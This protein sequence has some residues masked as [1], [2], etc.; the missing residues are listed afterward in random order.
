[1]QTG[2]LCTFKIS[3]PAS[4]DFNDVMYIK[5]ENLTDVDAFLLKGAERSAITGKFQI[6]S[7]QTYTASPGI[8]FYLVF[9]AKTTKADFSFALSFLSIDG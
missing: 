7:G 2:E 4:G 6:K 8:D 5:F 1:M 3:N 9:S